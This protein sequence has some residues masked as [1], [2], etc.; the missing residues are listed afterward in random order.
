MVSIIYIYGIDLML[1]RILNNITKVTN[2]H[3]EL[4]LYHNFLYTYLNGDNINISTY[5]V[6]V[7]DL[8]IKNIIIFR[9]NHLSYLEI[10]NND[11]YYNYIYLLRFKLDLLNSKFYRYI[12]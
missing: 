1:I 7:L 11:L 8:K 3:S 6:H 2:R 9:D 12:K 4:H 10:N 5:K